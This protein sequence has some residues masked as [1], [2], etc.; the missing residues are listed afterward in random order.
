VK[1]KRESVKIKEVF[2]VLSVLN[3]FWVPWKRA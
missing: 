1:F 2:P 3:L